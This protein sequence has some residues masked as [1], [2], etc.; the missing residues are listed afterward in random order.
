MQYFAGSLRPSQQTTHSLRAHQY[1]RS[2][3]RKRNED[4]DESPI[5][6]D[7]E[8]ADPLTSSNLLPFVSSNSAQT[9]QLRIAGLTPKHDAALNVPPRPFPH[10]PSQAQRP[11]FNATKIQ[12]ELADLDPPLFAAHAIS[13][14]RPVDRANAVPELRQTHLNVLVT[15]MHRCLLQ[16]DY[17]RAGRAWG[18]ILRTQVAGAPIDP[19]VGGRWGLGAEILLRRVA[20]NQYTL[21]GQ[22]EEE[23]IYTDEG[24]EL[25]REYYERL[26]VQYPTRKQY[27]N[28]IDAR[29]FYPAMFSLWIYE[30][31]EKSKRARNQHALIDP[32]SPSFT[33]LNDGFEHDSAIESD[34]RTE[35]MRHARQIEERLDRVIVSP[36][37]DKHPDLLQ[38]RGMISLWIGDLVLGETATSPSGDWDPDSSTDDTYINYEARQERRNRYT[39]S[40]REF[41]RALDYLKRAQ[42]HGKHLPESVA[43]TKD[44]I[45][46][47]MKKLEVLDH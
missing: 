9:A 17:Q 28:A 3:K 33:T 45:D 43:S 23:D 32:A 4:A 30:V 24:F 7:D 6:S 21:A 29:T 1:K 40:L 22:T 8:A 26:I 37:F 36:P 46:Y 27:R 14:S 18:M 10:A 20:R 25:A 19:R 34:I 44:K 41:N 39:H 38:L 13:K 16:G 2:R 5:N 15:L 42:E 47:L 12:Q 11:T 31:C 35:E